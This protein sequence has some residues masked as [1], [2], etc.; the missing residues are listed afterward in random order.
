MAYRENINGK[1]IETADPYDIT[2]D[3]KS[4]VNALRIVWEDSLR[5]YGPKG[6]SPLEKVVVLN[7]FINGRPVL[8]VVQDS[9]FGSVLVPAKRWATIQTRPGVYVR[10]RGG[11]KGGENKVVQAAI[12]RGTPRYKAQVLKFSE[13]VKR[14]DGTYERK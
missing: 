8:D 3:R 13:V 5:K 12:K 6:E 4:Y 9:E 11:T 1:G 14:Q 2:G 7:R 10:F